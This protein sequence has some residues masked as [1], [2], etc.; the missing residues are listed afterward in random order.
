VLV[1]AI[2]VDAPD[3][4]ATVVSVSLQFLS[5]KVELSLQLEQFRSQIYRCYCSSIVAVPAGS[6]N[7]AQGAI[8]SSTVDIQ[9]HAPSLSPSL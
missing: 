4:E 5:I 1:V 3:I 9:S 7:V 6:I 2:R 8:Y